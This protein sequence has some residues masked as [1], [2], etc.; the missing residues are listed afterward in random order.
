MSGIMEVKLP[1]SRFQIWL[2]SEPLGGLRKSR[3]HGLNLQVCRA[4]TGCVSWMVCGPALARG[5]R[6]LTGWLS[7]VP[8]TS[9]RH[10]GRGDPV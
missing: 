7:Q 10:A 5:G 4:L 3:L 1:A 2:Q 8:A 6:E 9:G